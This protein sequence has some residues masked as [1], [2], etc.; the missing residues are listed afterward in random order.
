MDAGKTITATYAPLV[1]RPVSAHTMVLTIGS[2]TMTVDGAKVALDASAA[3][4]EDRTFIPLRALVEQPGG[5]FVPVDRPDQL[6][7]E[8]PQ[9]DKGAVFEDCSRSIQ[10][11]FR[12]IHR[13]GLAP[14]GEDHGV[15]GDRTQHKRSIGSSNLL[16]GVHGDG[17]GVR[18]AGKI[19]G[20]AGEGVAG[21]GGS[22]KGNYCAVVIGFTCWHKGYS[23]VAHLGNGEGVG[24]VVG[25]D[26]DGKG[27]GGIDIRRHVGISPCNGEDPV[28]PTHEVIPTIRS[29]RHGGAAGSLIHRLG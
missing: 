12:T 15:R 20:P 6:L 28:A 13:H 4:F 19:T 29:G 1:L 23:T 18:A 9:W 5:A 27:G 8:G 11:D 22:S 17:R 26:V 10:C 24:V 2:K 25:V 7:H 14:N 16:A 3:I 21:G